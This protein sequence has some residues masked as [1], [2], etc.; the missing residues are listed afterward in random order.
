MQ[1]CQSTGSRQRGIGRYSMSLAQAMLREGR[2]HEFHVLLNAAF[3][4]TIEPIREKLKGQIPPERIRIFHAPP[5]SSQR[6][7]QVSWRTRAAEAIRRCAIQQIA[8][9]MVHVTSL[10][11]GLG[12]DCVVDIDRE[13]DGVPTAVTVYDLIPWLYAERYLATETTRAWYRRKLD[14]LRRA[15][16]LLGISASACSEA[17]SVLPDRQGK[18][19]NISSAANPDVFF[20]APAGDA[21]QRLGLLRPF[22]MYTGGI[23][24][25]K[26]IDGL[27]TAFAALPSSL[28]SNY[29][30][31][32]VCHADASARAHLL[33]HARQAGLGSTDVVLT[34][35]VSDS[36]L[37]DLYRSCELFVFPSLHEGF[38]LPALEA[39]MCGA[40]VIGSNTS[41]IPEV[42]GRDDALFD[43]SSQAAITAALHRALADE[44]YRTSLKAS[45]PIQAARFS[46]E[47]TARSALQAMEE[48]VREQ[49]RPSRAST[50]QRP[51]LA[52]HAPLAPARSGIAD[53]TAEL[54]PALEQYYDVELI[55][56]Q[57]S[58]T[59]PAH[60]QHLPVHDVAFFKQNARSYDRV[61]YQF[62]NSSYHAHMFQLLGEV[63]GTVVLHDFFLSGALAWMEAVGGVREAFREALLRSHG[64]QALDFDR[65]HGREETATRFPANRFVVERAEGVIVHSDWS[66]RS[67]D[68]FYGPGYSREW[69]RIPHLRALPGDGDRGR[70]RRELNLGSDDFLVCSFGH[71]EPTK[72]NDRLVDAWH[73][74]SLARD[75]RCRLVLV[76]NNPDS[77]Y[78]RKFQRLIEQSQRISITGYAP[79]P[80]YEQYLC[81]A[82]LAVQ[83]RAMSRGETSGAVLDSLSRGV[84]LIMNANGSN[85]EYPAEVACLLPDLFSDSELVEALERLRADEP[86]RRR[87]HEAGPAWIARHHDPALVARQ[88]R[89]A[90]EAFAAHPQ[91]RAYWAA[92]DAIGALGAAAEHD[93]AHAAVALE[94]SWARTSA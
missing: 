39:L 16:L 36:D 13:L 26:N 15:A 19:V 89:D 91:H 67:A 9:D 48:A 86:E 38:G 35:Y 72:L 66:K 71:I 73:A 22:V 11:E 10:F 40:A 77:S 46:W 61:L 53:Y 76:G 82:D 17:E 80:M 2:Q 85:A 5:E 7:T 30:L 24:W 92:V 43:P 51:R 6:E 63:P 60:L 14:S 33:G 4:E 18:V 21:A 49:H 34:G 90:I 52:M 74:S 88:Y 20:P 69:R 83:L 75:S 8:P 94:A 32:I 56:N 28:R 41:S 1:G 87:L 50:P 45:A 42:I 62:G 81:A 23:D 44:A 37:A 64:A 58:V 57:S 68:L 54:A 84:P 47:R 31:A 65:I 55:H 3:P 79:R 25:R 12:D 78:G 93:L 59:L 70:A 29:Q 27:V